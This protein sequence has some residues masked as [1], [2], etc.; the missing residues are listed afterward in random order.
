MD[1]LVMV[2]I[3]SPLLA[4]PTTLKLP[5]R[6]VPGKEAKYPAVPERPAWILPP[7]IA[8]AGSSPIV[9]IVSLNVA[10]WF[11]MVGSATEPGATGAT[12]DQLAPECTISYQPTLEIALG[13]V[14]VL[15]A[16]KVGRE[17]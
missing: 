3:V 2:V 4:A 5:L 13:V 17:N 11:A 15:I 14:L 6:A 10:M 9:P 1:A 8:V 12:T 7:E 16:A